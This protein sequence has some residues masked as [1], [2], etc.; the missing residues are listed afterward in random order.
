MQPIQYP[1]WF[2]SDRSRDDEFARRLHEKLRGE[3]LRVWFAPDDMQ[4]GKKLI[5]QN[6]RAIQVNATDP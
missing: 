6:D 2:I 4:G 3:K 1:S 5:E